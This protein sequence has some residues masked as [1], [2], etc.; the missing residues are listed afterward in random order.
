[1]IRALVLVAILPTLALADEWATTDRGMRVILK[2]DHTWVEGTTGTTGGNNGNVFR[3]PKFDGQ[4]GTTGSTNPGG[5][6]TSGNNH[7][8]PDEYKLLDYTVHTTQAQGKVCIRAKVWLVNNVIPQAAFMLENTDNVLGSD[9]ILYLNG[10]QGPTLLRLAMECT[11]Q[12]LC[13]ATIYGEMLEQR[14]NWLSVQ[15][16]EVVW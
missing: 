5:A 4:G 7:G 3:G 13:Q 2:Q 8:C 14:P 12:K 11:Y 16:H 1:M 6:I 9:G 15:A 10:L